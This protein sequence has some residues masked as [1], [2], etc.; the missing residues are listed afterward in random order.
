MK[1]IRIE[2]LQ[3]GTYVVKADTERFGEQEIMFESYRKSECVR[4]IL[5]VAAFLF[6]VT[7]NPMY[8]TVLVDW[9]GDER[10][11]KLHSACE[12]NSFL[13]SVYGLE[14]IYAYKSKDGGVY[15]KMI[16]TR[17]SFSLFVDSNGAVR[18]AP[19]VKSMEECGFY[20]GS[21]IFA[22]MG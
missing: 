14:N 7:G 19:P 17:S 15:I 1:N 11:Q 10:S 16:G 18:R 6:R 20:K 21:N 3:S 22:F 2:H 8:L 9:M 5:K 4:Y 13:T 12:R